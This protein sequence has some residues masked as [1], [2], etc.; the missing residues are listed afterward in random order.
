[1]KEDQELIGDEEL[2]R[3]FLN[4]ALLLCPSARLEADECEKLWIL[5]TRLKRIN[6]LL[7]L[8]QSQ[9]LE[10]NLVEMQEAF[11]FYFV[12]KDTSKKKKL[13]MNDHLTAHVQFINRLTKSS[14]LIAHYLLY[15]VRCLKSL[16]RVMNTCFPEVYREKLQDESKQQELNHVE[17][18]K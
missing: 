2:K 16:C 5:R 7:G 15:N 9:D 13:K 18:E 3:F 6:K 1:M 11:G 12:E 14:D 8:L 17:A 4:E 10:A